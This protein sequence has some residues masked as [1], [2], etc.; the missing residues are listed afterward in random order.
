MLCKDEASEFTHV[1]YTKKESITV[2]LAEY[3]F[4]S[5]RELDKKIE[6]MQVNY[7]SEFVEY[8]NKLLCV[9][10]LVEYL[11]IALYTAQRDVSLQREIESVDR[12][13]RTPLIA[14]KI[15]DS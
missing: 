14:S 15:E 10:E 3:F 7:G 12:M 8:R 2:S 5:E 4:D 6:T 13:A 11:K 9:K 1:Y